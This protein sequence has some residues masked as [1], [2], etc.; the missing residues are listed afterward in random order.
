M[1]LWKALVAVGLV[2]TAVF[3]YAQSK[4]NSVEANKKVVY[5]FYRYVWEP[6]N[7]DNFNTY[8]SANYVEHNP[9]F[10]G[11]RENIVSALRGGIFGPGWTKPGKIEDTLKDP[12]ALII[13]EGDLVQWIFKRTDKDPKDPS[14]TYDWF[15]F[16]TFRVKD[17]KI[18]EHWDQARLR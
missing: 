7:L 13:A 9:M 8:T 2:L 10:P 4:A 16:D 3:A 11:K 18:V 15:S 17:G 5:D 14:K 12:P 6:K 1:K